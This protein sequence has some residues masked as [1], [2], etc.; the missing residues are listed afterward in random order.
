MTP[1]DYVF[2]AAEVALATKLPS[3]LYAFTSDHAVDPW[4]PSNEIAVPYGSRPWLACVDLVISPVV[5]EIVMCRWLRPEMGIWTAGCMF[6]LLHG[7]FARGPRGVVIAIQIAA[8]GILC[9]HAW[10]A[11]GG[12][13]S[14]Y[15]WALGAHEAWNFTVFAM[16]L[17]TATVSRRWR[18]GL[19]VMCYGD[20]EQD[21]IDAEYG[22]GLGTEFLPPLRTGGFGDEV[23]PSDPDA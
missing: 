8:L 23:A 7:L 19:P 15:L 6:G 12:G 1:T 14:G 5:E 22:D 13:W 16:G 21:A 9:G 11:G 2:I 20:G 4:H 3:F 18:F 10:Q 17:L